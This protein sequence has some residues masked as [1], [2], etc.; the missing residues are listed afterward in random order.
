VARDAPLKA[1]VIGGGPG[2]LFSA[3]LL[4]LRHPGWEVTVHERLQP[5]TTYGFG[6][7]LTGAL[8]ESIHAVDPETHAN[9]LD[10]AFRATTGRFLLPSNT[11]NLADFNSGVAIGRTDLLRVLLAGAEHAGVVVRQGESAELADLRSADLVVAADGVSS[12]VREH[13]APALRPSI[14]HGRGL[15]IWCGSDLE[16]PGATFLPVRTRDG[17][18][19]AHAYPYAAGRSTVDIETDQETWRAAGLD[20]ATGLDPL[21]GASDERSLDYLSA[22]FGTLTGGRRLLGNKSRWAHFRVVSCERWVHEN[23]VLLGDAAATAHPSLGS[24]TKL[25]MDS[26]IAL[27]QA[28]SAPTADVHQALR[29][30]EAARRPAVDRLQGRA[31]RSQLWWESF[32]RRLDLPPV[33]VA[34]SFLSRAGNLTLEDRGDGAD[35]I[36]ARAVANYAGVPVEQTPSDGLTEWILDRPLSAAGVKLPSRVVP[37]ADLAG[38]VPVSGVLTIADGDAWGPSG[39]L[40]LDQAVA[41]LA[42]GPGAILLTGPDDQVAVLDRLALGERLRTELGAL[43][44]VAVDRAHLQDAADGLVAGRTDLI[45]LTDGPAVPEV[46]D[47]PSPALRGTR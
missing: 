25:A 34:V 11:V 44:V 5:G 47:A 26:A 23:V 4:K 37:V 1:E 13:L 9:V 46:A 22:V 16:L 12:A 10:V 18:F 21:S 33:Q 31:R 45:A 41:L 8:L 2:G 19:V 35:G 38:A 27:H 15:F 20:A 40:V 24:G 6:V 36:V 14:T 7:G 39:Q 42:A 30:Y 17:L 3:R 32:G 28:F 29:A 43:V